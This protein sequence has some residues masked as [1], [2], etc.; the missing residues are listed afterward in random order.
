MNPNQSPTKKSVDHKTEKD[1]KKKRENQIPACCFFL[2]QIQMPRRLCHIFV[3]KI[4]KKSEKNRK[5]DASFFPSSPSSLFSSPLCV[6]VFLAST[7]GSF[8]SLLRSLKFCISFS[9]TPQK[10]LNAHFQAALFCPKKR[11]TNPSTFPFFSF[12][13][14]T[15]TN[16][17][18]E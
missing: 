13:S 2:L 1:N 12:Q 6:C 3:A 9:S 8:F 16:R 17:K 15:R 10:C 18:K 7:C 14:E 11:G 5:G 4:K